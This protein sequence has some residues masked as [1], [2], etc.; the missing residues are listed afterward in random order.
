LSIRLRFAARSPKST[1]GITWICAAIEFHFSNFYNI[2]F[3]S[4][5]IQKSKL[6]SMRPSS[7]KKNPKGSISIVYLRRKR[8]DILR[9]AILLRDRIQFHLQRH[10]TSSHL[11]P[12]R[13]CNF[14]QA[15]QRQQRAAQQPQF[16]SPTN[17]LRFNEVS[18]NPSPI[19]KHT[20]S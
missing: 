5:I 20:I 10:R 13:N 11:N 15:T 1:L 17:V 7:S 6:N 16:S 18:G 2:R 19:L 3:L 14:S 8:T 4:S 12:Y 9:L